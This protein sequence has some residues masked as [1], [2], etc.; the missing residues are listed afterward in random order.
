M[1][2]P[3]ATSESIANTVACCLGITHCAF[4][5]SFLSG[6]LSHLWWVQGPDRLTKSAGCQNHRHYRKLNESMRS[7]NPPPSCTSRELRAPD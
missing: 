3:E 5:T 4:H 6:V 1:G 2:M 7:P